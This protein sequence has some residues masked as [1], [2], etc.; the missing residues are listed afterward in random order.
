MKTDKKLL[1]CL[2]KARMIM[3][4]LGV[5]ED[6]SPLDYDECPHE[7]WTDEGNSHGE[8]RC[9]SGCGIHRGGL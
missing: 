8:V 3:I 7:E 9:M 2:I 6:P 4:R 1:E 5:R